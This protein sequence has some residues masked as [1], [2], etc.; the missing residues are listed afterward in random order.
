LAVNGV[1][2]KPHLFFL[3]GGHR[4][5]PMDPEILYHT[6]V[7]LSRRKLRK[8]QKKLYNPEMWILCKIT[9]DKQ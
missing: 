5:R 4:P 2:T 8:M 9:I 3:C 1:A 6:S 7:S